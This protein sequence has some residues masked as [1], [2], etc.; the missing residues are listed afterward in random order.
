MLIGLMLATSALEGL[1]LGALLPLLTL[2]TSPET[3]A[4]GPFG[5]LAEMLQK[6]DQRT[7]ITWIL[8]SIFILFLIKNAFQA[9][10]IYM[11]ARFVLRHQAEAS[12]R[13]FIKTLKRPLVDHLQTTSATALRNCTQSVGQLFNGIL[14]PILTLLSET[15]TLIAILFVLLSA[16]PLMTLATAALLVAPSVLVTTALRNP[17]R[18]WGKLSH[19]LYERIL[20][21]LQQSLALVREIKVIQAENHFARAHLALAEGHAHNAERQVF[22]QEIPRLSIEMSAITAMLVLAGFTVV[23][24]GSLVRALP[25]LGL[26]AAASFRLLPSANR[27]AGQINSLSLNKAAFDEVI[28]TLA[29]GMETEAS[30]RDYFQRERSFSSEVRLQHVTFRYPGQTHAVLDNVSLSLRKGTAIGIKGASGGGK[31][32]LVNVLLGLLRPEAG[33]FIIDDHPVSFEAFQ[34]LRV[35]YV[36]QDVVLLDDT[37]RNNVAFGIS[38]GEIDEARLWKTLDQAHLSDF[39]RSLPLGL[40]TVLGERGSRLSGGQKQRLSIARALYHNPELLVFDE[41][42]SAL[43]ADTEKVVTEAFRELRINKSLVIIAHREATLR[44]C[45]KILVMRDGRLDVSPNSA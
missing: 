41:A 30:A 25:I 17:L 24:E 19:D 21:T 9:L 3:F 34:L 12:N 44:Y 42:T 45:D 4:S 8:V 29:E 31:T 37:I 10:A 22:A 36:A 33:D 13:L 14:M 28:G 43:D 11:R 1:S 39:V 23:N 27:I 18:R 20:H 38:S 26:F 5:A 2:I 15:L 40:D 32:T 35:G 7:A 6:Y 16:A